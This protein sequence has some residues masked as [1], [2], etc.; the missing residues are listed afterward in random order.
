MSGLGP[1]LEAFPF[2]AE[3]GEHQVQHV[4]MKGGERGREGER[5][6]GGEGKREKF[7]KRRMNSSCKKVCKQSFIHHA[8]EMR[9]G[10]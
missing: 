6:R 10:A 2:R 3:P 7:S 5:E 8:V 9:E 4:R 1:H